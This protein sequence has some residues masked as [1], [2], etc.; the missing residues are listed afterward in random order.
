MDGADRRQCATGRIAANGE[1]RAIQPE[2][3]RALARQPVQ[4]VPG[5][6]HGGGEAVPG[7]SRCP[8]TARPRRLLPRHAAHRVVR[9]DAA[10]GEAA[11]VQVQQHRQASS[12]AGAHQ[13]R[14]LALP[15]ARRDAQVL[16]AGQLGQGTSST[17][18][19]AA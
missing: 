10:D 19:D 7:A 14:R 5:V 18:M 2:R 15:I 11:A 17:P 12:V 3:C 13:A 1:A 6:V 16:H 8:A 9:L 4:R